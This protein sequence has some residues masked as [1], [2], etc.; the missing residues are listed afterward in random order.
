M[1]KRVYGLKTQSLLALLISSVVA[2]FVFC[3]VNFG[4]SILLNNYF[5]RSTYIKQKTSQYMDQ[6]ESYVKKHK[7]E[8]TD[9]A[10]I[11]KWLNAHKSVSTILYI[12]RDGATIYDSLRFFWQNGISTE[13][14]EQVTEN[15]FSFSKGANKY[16]GGDYSYNSWFLKRELAFS[17][18]TAIVSLYGY[19]D[20][21]VDMIA[22]IAEIILTC[23]VFCIVFILLIQKKIN[24]VIQLEREI[25]ILETGGLDYELTVKGNDELSSLADGLNQMRHALSDNIKTE[26]AAVK[27]NYDL[28]VAVSHDL[29][30]PLTTLAL[31][32]DLIH[33]GTYKDEEQLHSY[34]EKCRNKVL[35]IKQMTDQLFE[36]FY[37]TKEKNVVLEKPEFVRNVF[38]DYLSNMTGYLS[39]NGFTIENDI[40]W[41]LFKVSV[42]IDYLSR[43]IDNISSNIIKYADPNHP[44][45][46]VA[47]EKTGMFRIKLTN[48]IRKLEAKPE[49]TE[50]GVQNI[51]FMMEKMNGSCKVTQL[52][53]IY[54]IQLFFPNHNECTF[55]EEVKMNDN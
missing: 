8:A 55:G 21:L 15:E 2:V 45:Q 11:D 53:D 46:F 18:G 40:L 54:T 42:S 37:L 20:K 28:V 29:R 9:S 10:A 16:V 7:I 23:F 12:N 51:H 30:T 6:F 33:E 14:T 4:V 41:P 47:G 38:E 44:V 24:Y 17:D 3:A 35:R 50:V 48:H 19:F 25:K 26:A 34:L 39:D 5:E 1:N 22:L 52:K 27:S 32:L 49:S 43:I 36:R 31:Y 13:N